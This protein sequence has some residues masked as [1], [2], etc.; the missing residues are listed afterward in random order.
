MKIWKKT[1]LLAFCFAMTASI[2][3]CSMAVE[4]I[5]GI[6]GEGNAVSKFLNGLMGEE[7]SS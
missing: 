7:S 5:D 6:L 4:K 2:S 3:S 1:M